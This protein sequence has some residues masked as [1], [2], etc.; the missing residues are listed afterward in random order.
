M[1]FFRHHAIVVT[2]GDEKRTQE[3]RNVADWMGCIVSDIVHGDAEPAYSFFVAPDGAKELCEGTSA[4]HDYRRDMLIA[5]FV[6][7]N[8]TRGRFPFD[9]VE[10]EF[11]GDTG[12]AKILRHGD[13]PRDEATK[14]SDRLT[15]INR[16][17]PSWIFTGGTI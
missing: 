15:A 3:V 7:Q 4:D 6:E 9:W 8:K 14:E 5:W 1:G 17:P 13:D 11:G 12:G 10:L 16:E 2:C